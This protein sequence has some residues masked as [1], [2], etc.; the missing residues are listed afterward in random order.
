VELE[1]AL[2]LV[3]AVGEMVGDPLDLALVE[4]GS[5]VGDEKADYDSEDDH[6]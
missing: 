2:S 1:A 3:E 4:A 6:E 5:E